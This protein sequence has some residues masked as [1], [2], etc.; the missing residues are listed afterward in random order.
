[1]SID[2]RKFLKLSSATLAGLPLG[3][4]TGNT[5]W[6]RT[7]DADEASGDE[8]YAA[9]KD[10]ANTAKPSVRWWW[11]GLRVVKEELIRE[12]DMLKEIGVGGVEINSIRFPD[13]SDPLGYKEMQWLS[14]EWVD[15]IQF[16]V[17]AAKE[18]GMICDIIM[19][20]GW[21]FGGEFLTGDEQTQLMALG[22]LDVA[23]PKTLTLSRS[24]LIALVDPPVSS[25]NPD[26]LKELWFMRLVP[27]KFNALSE[28]TDLDGQV[29]QDRITVEVPA[30]NHVLYF[31]VKI[32]GYMTVIYGA[33]GAAGPVL[34]HYHKEAVQKYLDRMSDAL[35]PKK[36]LAGFRSVFTDSMELQGANWCIDMPEQFR[37]RRGYDLLPFLPFILFKTGSQG[38]HINAQYGAAFGMELKETLERVRYDFEVTKMDLFRERFLDVFLDWCKKNGVRSRVQAYGRE[39]Y[40]LDSSLDTDIPECETWLRSY[41]GAPLKDFDFKS[42]RAYSPINKW[43]SSASHLSGKRIT[44]CEEITNTEV[45]FNATLQ[46]IKQTGDQSNMTGVTHSILHGFNYCPKEAPFPGWIRYGCYFNERNTWW[47]Y[48]HQ[49]IAYKAR[50]SAVFQN[51]DMVADIAVMAP[52]ADLWGKYTAQWDPFPERAYPE[53]LYN[54][55]EAIHQ[56]GSGCDYVTERILQHASFREGKLR[57]G[58]REYKALIVVEVETMHPA[59]A[60]ALQRYAEAGGR[61]IF[62]EKYPGKAPGYHQHETGDRKVKESIAAIMHRKNV[63]LYPA[64]R[65]DERIIDWYRRLQEKYELK[66]YIRIDNPQVMVSQVYYRSAAADAFFINNFSST[67]RFSMTAEFDVP[68]GRTAWLWDPETGERFLY[69]VNGKNNRLKIALGPAE[70]RLIVFDETKKGNEYVALRKPEKAVIVIDKPWTL[71]LNHYDGT[72]RTMKLGKLIDFRDD[73]RLVGFAGTAVYQNDFDVTDPAQLNTLDL[74]KVEGITE[75]TL[76][77]VSLGNRWYGDHL[78]DIHK[79]VRAGRNELSIRL[80]TTLGNY[81]ATSLKENKDTIKWIVKKK[82]SL[83]PQGIL[84][85]VILG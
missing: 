20:S 74:G 17:T 83:Y 58:P 8:L 63:T 50:L 2:R 34:N 67:E 45:V 12:L 47:P 60:K 64:P 70:T 53:Y 57:Y 39:F 4:L 1:M 37:Q 16:A 9:F 46:R 61:I 35:R 80:V 40:P 49:W 76:N 28:V 51:G 24:E 82:Q 73:N 25:K 56:N 22:T 55:W 69:P 72:E 5:S 81:M 36:G 10:P 6:Y 41:V 68:A 23:G 62:I 75:V 84:G 30:G 44:S 33:P 71:T 59:T 78:Y 79:N 54:V 43:V 32:T 3:R 29:G 85:P 21:P 52:L 65:P 77:G 7:S 11:N 66:P 42:G 26:S 48:L 31:L 15:L 18:R 27:A 14:E 38:R 19:G 13:T